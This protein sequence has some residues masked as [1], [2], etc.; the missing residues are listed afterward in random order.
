M[1]RLQRW[2]QK[3]FF[4]QY[5]PYQCTLPDNVRG[6]LQ[7]IPKA[8]IHLHLEGSMDADTIWTLAQKYD[9]P[10]IRSKNDADWALVFHSPQ[11]FF[12]QFLKVSSLLREADDFA[13][14]ARQ[15][16]SRFIAENIQYAEITLAPHKF[17]RNG[18][19]YPD[20]IAAIDSGLLDGMKGKDFSYNIIIDIVRD[21]GPQA[22]METMRMV[23]AH[24]HPNVAA[25]GLGG[26]ENY[27]PEASA[28][29]FQFAESLGLHKTAHAGEGREP[30]SIWGAL[31][32]LGVKRIDHGLRAIEDPKLV[33]YLKE[34]QIH[35]N[36]CP[37]SN[38]MLGV[39]ASHEK[40]PL[41]YYYEQGIPVNLS[42]DDPSFFCTTLTQEYEKVVELHGIPLQDIPAII[43]NALDASF[44][45]EEKK[46][47]LKQTFQH[48][49][50]QRRNEFNISLE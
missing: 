12:E 14:L 26:G 1:K 18:I 50:N 48:E 24:P 21:L 2:M 20:I 8:E 32:H 28:E 30:E 34:H 10:N 15:V 49:T 22:G 11:H 3:R 42:T 45:P 6:Y 38:V 40:H 25:I 43:T 17:V 13:L 27:V 36:M 31:Q 33:E 39:A 5:R 47:A 23:A 4:R 44:L 7:R 29:V 9:D 41:R 35:L 37:S 19:P 46:Q 16:A